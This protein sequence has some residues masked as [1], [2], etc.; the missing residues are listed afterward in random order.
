MAQPLHK[1][2]IL[3]I[4]LPDAPEFN[5]LE[6]FFI[7]RAPQRKG[8]T[9]NYI[10]LADSLTQRKGMIRER[11]F[12]SNNADSEIAVHVKSQE[13]AILNNFVSRIVNK[14]DFISTEDMEYIKSVIITCFN[15]TVVDHNV[16][17]NGKLPHDIYHVSCDTDGGIIPNICKGIKTGG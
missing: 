5:P 14:Y 16:R 3:S 15:E 13:I 2:V 12:L 11:V 8:Y 1:R 9:H 17:A 10:V 7:T 6:L 4:P